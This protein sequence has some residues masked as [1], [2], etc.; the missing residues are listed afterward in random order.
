MGVYLYC[1]LPEGAP[2]PGVAGL[3]GAPLRA[4]RAAGVCVWI[5]DVDATPRV[6]L[7]RIRKHDRVIRS[8]MDAGL[9]PVPIRFGQV[10]SDDHALR[11]H[12]AEHDYGPVLER[13][14]GAV[15]FGVRILDP[16]SKPEPS[17]QPEGA[18]GTAGHATG[19]GAAHLHALAA[20]FHAAE[21]RQARALDA[22]R[23][24]DGRLAECVRESRIEATDQPAGAVVAHLVQTD[25]ALAYGARARELAEGYPPLR[26]V[27]TGPWPP[28][29]FVDR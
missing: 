2:E 10:V 5:G 24:L 18:A 25:A 23:D 7:S 12:L 13:I 8:A 3:D 26:I 4:V 1:V 17:R 14:E 29:S 6:D 11:A 21:A 27:V 19:S 9:S 15:E 16:E 20:R 28:Y 22:A